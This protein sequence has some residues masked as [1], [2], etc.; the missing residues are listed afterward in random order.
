M[1]GCLKSVFAIV[2][3]SF[4]VLG[5]VV[6]LCIAACV[7]VI[8]LYNAGQEAK[9]EEAQDLN[10]GYGERGK[11]IA[12]GTFAK[13]K[14]GEIRAVRMEVPADATVQTMNMFNSEPDAGSEYALVWFE[15]KCDEQT[16]SEMTLDLKLIDDQGQEWGEK[17]MITLDNDLPDSVR[18]A[19]AEGWQV[20]QVPI[21]ATLNLLKVK[22]AGATLYTELPQAG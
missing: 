18:G 3:G 19:T 1:K 20:F 11:P 8:V 6:F 13:F 4:I 15:M 2:T 22:W 14:E 17:H 7:V 9:T 16:C 10:D 5:I 21:G 12:A